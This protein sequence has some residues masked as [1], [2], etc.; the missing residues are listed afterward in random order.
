MTQFDGDGFE[1]GQFTPE[2]RAGIREMWRTLSKDY[3]AMDAE[4][5]SSMKSATGFIKAAVLLS[6]I[7]AVCTPIGI[8][9]AFW[10]RLG[11]AG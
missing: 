7:I 3:I 10:V 6:K 9:A 4:T 11:G 1:K 2:E 5:V 8:A